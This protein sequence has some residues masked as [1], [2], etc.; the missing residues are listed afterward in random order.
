MIGYYFF[1]TLHRTGPNVAPFLISVDADDPPETEYKALL[2]YVDRN[3]VATFTEL[4]G[5]EK[6]SDNGLS[7]ETL[8]QVRIL[9]L[10]G[11]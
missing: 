2:S 5:Y 9:T 6:K 1:S 4:D 8:F 7:Y 10:S 11:F 3:I